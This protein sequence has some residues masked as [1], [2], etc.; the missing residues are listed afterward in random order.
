MTPVLAASASELVSFAESKARVHFY[1]TKAYQNDSCGFTSSLP[2]APADLETNFSKYSKENNVL[3]LYNKANTPS[4]PSTKPDATITVRS[5]ANKWVLIHEYMH[6]LF[7]NQFD[8]D[9]PEFESDLQGIFLRAGQDYEKAKKELKQ[10]SSDRKDKVKFVKEKLYK[11]ADMGI[12]ILKVFFLEE[13][14]IEGIL[15]DLMDNGKLKV[16]HPPQRINGAGYILTTAKTAEKL[17]EEMKNEIEDFQS[18]YSSELESTDRTPLRSV[19]NKY[20]SLSGD[21]QTLKRKARLFLSQE[22]LTFNGLVSSSRPS[23]EGENN[24][25]PGCKH[26]DLNPKVIEAFERFSSEK[27]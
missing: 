11:V 18:L 9:R 27:M 5:D 16:V 7:H 24:S 23:L 20:D 15:G 22:N 13:M 6:H 21:M 4:L 8:K 1:K 10:Q 12:D 25:K 2:A 19:L 17:I 3:G 14:T 26:N